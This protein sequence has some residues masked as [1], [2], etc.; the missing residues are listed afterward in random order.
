MYLNENEYKSKH[1]I[2]TVKD[3]KSIRKCVYE[4]ENGYVMYIEVTEVPKE[5]ET[6]MKYKT[7]TCT[8]YISKLNPLE[9]AKSKEDTAKDLMEMFEEKY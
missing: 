6:E 1:E 7:P 5:G 4:V 9:M 3:S 2:T 8:V